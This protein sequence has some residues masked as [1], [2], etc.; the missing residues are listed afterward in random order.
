MFPAV[1]GP[2]LE[3]SD[4]AVLACCLMDN[5]CH[6]ALITHGAHLSA[7]MRQLNGLY[8]QRFN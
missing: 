5:P 7:L 2:M 4:A 6:L 3:R 8:T 1:L